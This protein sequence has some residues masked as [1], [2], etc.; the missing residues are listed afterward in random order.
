MPKKANTITLCKQQSE[1]TEH[2]CQYQTLLKECAELLLDMQ[3]EYAALHYSIYQ[4]DELDDDGYGDD[5][6]DVFQSLY[7]NAEKTINKLK[8]LKILKASL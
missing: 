2:K 4:D 8:G 3:R 7:E 5:D 1:S 6:N